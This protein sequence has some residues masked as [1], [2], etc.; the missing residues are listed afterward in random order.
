MKVKY[1][2]DRNMVRT[3]AEPEQLPAILGFTTPTWEYKSLVLP[4]AA[5]LNQYGADGWELVST[6]PAP[7]DQTVFHFKRV[8]Q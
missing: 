2:F 3:Q 4:R 8:K 6:V 5:D 7:C 1:S